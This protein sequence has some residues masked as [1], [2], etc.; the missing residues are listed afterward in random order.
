MREKMSKCGKWNAILPI[1]YYLLMHHKG[2]QFF[3]FAEFCP[4][5]RGYH[6]LPNEGGGAMKKLEGSQNFF[7][8]NSGSQKK[9]RDYW[10]ATNFNENFVQ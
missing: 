2:S 6:F 8:R 9:S 1:F 4:L 5:I 3:Y 10:V 7:M